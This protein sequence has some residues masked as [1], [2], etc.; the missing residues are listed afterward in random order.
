MPEIITIIDHK[1]PFV[2]PDGAPS[3]QPDPEVRQRDVIARRVR[4]AQRIAKAKADLIA[5]E[6]AVVAAR[7]KLFR[8][9]DE[10][11]EE[12]LEIASRI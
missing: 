2:D 8:L 6:Q 5:A 3:W 12:T 9:V 1:A 4:S 11:E 7:E 10:L